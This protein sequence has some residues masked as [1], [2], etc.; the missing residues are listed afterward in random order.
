MHQ[1]VKL[2][3]FDSLHTLVQP[4]L[5]IYLQYSQEF[6]PF[7]GELA[8]EGIK[9]AFTTGSFL[10]SFTAIFPI[11]NERAV[12][13]ILQL[14]GTYKKRDPFTKAPRLLI[15]RDGGRKSSGGRLWELVLIPLV[16]LLRAGSLLSSGDDIEES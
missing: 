16:G 9:A 2:I 7:L 11:I 15:M 1:V 6:K 5:P 3:T 8:P 14:S 10:L 12:R 13:R 4:R